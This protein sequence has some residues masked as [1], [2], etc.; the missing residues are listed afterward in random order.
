M[1]QPIINKKTPYTDKN[2]KKLDWKNILQIHYFQH[3]TNMHVYT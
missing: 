1:G 3:L 2:Y